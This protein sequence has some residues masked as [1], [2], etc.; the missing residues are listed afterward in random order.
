MA[1][2]NRRRRHRTDLS[3]EAGLY[4]LSLALVWH[5]RKNFFCLKNLFRGHRNGLLGNLRNIGEPGF[6]NLLLPAS[7]IEID[8]DVRL[9]S[10]KVGRRI[11]K[12]DVSILA[13]SEEGDVN[14]R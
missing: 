12:R 6:T 14:R 3:L 9:L 5:D 11:V 2:Q 1:S 4:R 10:V 13:N 7:L 8:D